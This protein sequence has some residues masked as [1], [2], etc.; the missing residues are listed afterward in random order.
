MAEPKDISIDD[1][2]GTI[3]LDPTKAQCVEMFRHC[4]SAAT[5][6]GR[7]K[8]LIWAADPTMLITAILCET[9][10]PH[11]MVALAD[12]ILNAAAEA[13]GQRNAFTR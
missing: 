13:T 8:M 9:S 10:S 12:L 4:F 7:R 2:A 1:I 11:R 6:D 5:T 3:G